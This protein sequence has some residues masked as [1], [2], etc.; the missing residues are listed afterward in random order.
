MQRKWEGRRWAVSSRELWGWSAA[1]ICNQLHTLFSPDTR[2]CDA[3][4]ALLTLTRN[5][6]F[7]WRIWTAEARQRTRPPAEAEYNASECWR[8]FGWIWMLHLMCLCLQKF[9]SCISWAKILYKDEVGYL[10]WSLSSS[11]PVN[12]DIFW[13]R[14]RFI[15]HV[16]FCCCLRIPF[17]FFFFHSEWLS[18]WRWICI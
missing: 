3:E 9:C 16:D 17:S 14:R 6:G 11:R 10:C 15:R 8:L 2:A 1:L 18:A 13:R 7:G 4:A 5:T 12:S